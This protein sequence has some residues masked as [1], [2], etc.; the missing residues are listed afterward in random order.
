M[1]TPSSPRLRLLL[2]A[3]L[4]PLL[5]ARWGAGALS[6]PAAV[7]GAAVSFETTGGVLPGA[8]ED[9]LAPAGRDGAAQDAVRRTVTDALWSCVGCASYRT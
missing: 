9:E 8:R 1:L 6:G 5:P 3:S 2:E 7:F 4:N